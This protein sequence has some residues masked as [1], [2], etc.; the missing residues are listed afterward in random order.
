MSARKAFG[1]LLPLLVAISL[2]A[3]G[4]A[5]AQT[6]LPPSLS[7]DT[8]F[9][10]T[11]G[12][13]RDNATTTTRDDAYDVAVDGD[14][15]Y[16]VG[17][18]GG[19]VAIYARRTN[20][21]FDSGFSE[22]GRLVLPVA[23]GTRRDIGVAIVVLPDHR[24]RVLASTNFDTTSTTNT[25]VAIVG[26]LAD[27]MPDLAFGAADGTEDG[28]VIFP[29]TAAGPDTPTRMTADS[30]GRL[31]VS[32]YV[33]VANRDDS[34][35]ALRAADGSPVTGFGTNGIKVLDR[36]L[37]NA[38]TKSDRAVDV[39]F[40]PG[41]GLLA[42]MQVATNADGLTS[43][44]AVLH[45][46]TET[47]ADD[48]GFSG[49]GDLVLEVGEPNTIPGALR[50][51]AGQLWVT[52]STRVGAD[53]DAFLA[54]VEADGSGLQFRRFDMR[55]GRIAENQA[56]ISRAFD[57]TVVPGVPNT[58]VVVGSVELDGRPFWAAAAFNGIEGPLAG[59]GFGDEV[60]PT[61]ENA[62][63]P[64]GAAAGSGWVA[65][66]ATLRTTSGAIETAFGTVR[67]L[68]DAEKR[69]D[70]AVEVPAP[71]ELVFEGSAPGTLNVKV[72]NAGTK[73]CAGLITV[74]A[75]YGLRLGA[76]TG[77]LPTG[78]LLPGASYVTGPAAVTYAG[79]RQRDDILRVQVSSA[80]DANAENDVSLL[81]VVFSYC[82]LQLGR[83]GSSALAPSEGTRTFE[84]T[85]RNEGTVPCRRS[86]IRTGSG[87]RPRRSTEPVTLEGG[88]SASEEIAAAPAGRR[89]VGSRAR[90]A[91]RAL[92]DADVENGNDSV[93]LSPLIVGVGDTNARRPGPR[94]RR[95]SGSARGGRG[96]V[97]RARLR[98]I[99][100]HVAVRRLGRGCRWLASSEGSLRK[101]SGRRCNR[102]VWLRAEGTRRWS[103]ALRSALPRG[104]YV[105]YSRATISAGG[106]REASFS[107]RDRNRIVFRS[108]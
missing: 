25:D 88:R 8:A 23:S 69:C 60:I 84:F 17:E 67:L 64:M 19:D 11:T 54:R 45:G 29:V 55:G 95:L 92:A 72:T 104:R 75:P 83:A 70:L 6:I 52:G 99:R 34:F 58:M 93:V 107:A 16:T 2:L 102:P 4:P 13:A 32:G 30:T 53:T 86:R 74:P 18:S 108:R 101:G 44:V 103:F 106:F 59:A 35:I 36:G 50:V 79:P 77:S 91:F 63:P 61:T 46:F 73:A 39:A 62:D 22:D 56:V 10:P 105:L 51:H 80:A 57:L 27:G 89:R 15:I 41:G 28:R 71:L 21:T 33:T 37:S 65:A 26:L 66:S 81:R 94:A 78:L 98:V 40:R 90:M 14:R 1:S 20:G 76:R 24:L 12:V 48:T 43:L 68:I 38:V 5:S 9:A 96:P 87:V 7:V 82:D 100:V 47:G 3:A 42:L 31:A 97:K 49:D 85:L